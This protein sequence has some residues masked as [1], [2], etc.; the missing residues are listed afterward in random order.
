MV[1]VVKIILTE[2]PVTK[3]PETFELAKGTILNPVVLFFILFILR[4]LV[5]C[6]YLP[7]NPHNYFISK[8]NRF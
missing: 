1:P 3:I 2:L 6:R 7:D 8:D 4:I 5:N